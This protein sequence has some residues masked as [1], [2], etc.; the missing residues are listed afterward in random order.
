[1]RAREGLRTARRKSQDAQ[2]PAAAAQD[3]P[4][5][6]ADARIENLPVAGIGRIELALG[7][8]PVDDELAP[9]SRR[10]VIAP[11]EPTLPVAGTVLSSHRHRVMAQAVG[12]FRQQHAHAIEGQRTERGL[13]HARE[14]LAELERLADQPGDRGHDFEGCRACRG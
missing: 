13:G 6:G 8:D 14:D 5:D 9:E 2:G 7:V 10:A 12:A 11:H 3:A 1:V 4:D